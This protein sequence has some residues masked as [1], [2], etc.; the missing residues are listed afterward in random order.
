MYSTEVFRMEK[1]FCQSQASMKRTNLLYQDAIMMLSAL[2]IADTVNIFVPLCLCV[3][4]TFV[5]VR[6]GHCM[7]MYPCT[8]A[9]VFACIF[10]S[11][12]G[13]YM[14]VYLSDVQ[15][16]RPG[17]RSCWRA[18]SA[19]RVRR[20]RPTR[21]ARPART[22]AASLPSFTLSASTCCVPFW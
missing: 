15:Q 19:S 18:C 14:H 8:S 21:T 3:Y 13:V 2:H 12:L 6:V 5:Y 4:L 17:R 9:H 7:P 22:A 11:T 10:A 16:A 20:D 1:Q